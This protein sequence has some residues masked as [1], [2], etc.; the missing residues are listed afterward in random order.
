MY[1]TT[2]HQKSI[3]AKLVLQIYK[4]INTQIN[5]G[6]DQLIA[7]AFFFGMRSYEY[8]K[9]PKG[10]EKHTRILQKRYIRLYR[11][12]RKLSHNNWI[13]HLD[14]KV[15]PELIIQ[16]NRVKNATVTQWRTTITLYPV[17]IWAEIII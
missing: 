15:T 12:C 8:L 11:K 9:N 13:L 7:G 1:P 14:D 10:E 2:K 5:T 6:I 4:R 17:R 16:K 3:P